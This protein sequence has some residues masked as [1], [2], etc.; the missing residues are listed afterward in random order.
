MPKESA[1]LK[2]IILIL[3]TRGR[4]IQQRKVNKTVGIKKRELL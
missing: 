4:L 3:L 1:N 2:L